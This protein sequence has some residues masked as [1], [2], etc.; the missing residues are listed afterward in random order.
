MFGL[1]NKKD[2]GISVIDKIWMS[3]QAK[4]NACL[5]MQ[6]ERS[7]VMFVAWFE[8]TKSKSQHYFREHQIDAEV[9]LADH[10]NMVHESKELIF[11]EHHPLRAEEEK[12]AV[13]LGR[14]SITVLSLLTEPIFQ[15]FGSERIIEMMRKM[16][17]QEDEMIEHEMV[18]RSIKQAQDK[19][20]SRIS[21]NASA[22]SQGDWFSMTGVGTKS[23]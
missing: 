8:E 17:M 2:K 11:L 14:D 23:L 20:A 7:D 3:D 19:I 22:K 4:L 15:L 10:L 1:F 6:M 13:S 5:Q 18:S 12:K 9:Y 21:V 16:G